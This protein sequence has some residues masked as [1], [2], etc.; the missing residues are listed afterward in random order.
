MNTSK[1]M[2]DVHHWLFQRKVSGMSITDSSRAVMLKDRTLL[3]GAQRFTLDDDSVKLIC[4]LSHEFD[5]LEGWSFLARLPY[6]VTW[7][8]LSL[9]TKVRE[10][11]QM[12]K[13]RYKFNPEEVSPQI[14]YLMYRDA[15]DTS[16]PRWVCQAFLR[17]DNGEIMPSIVAY[18]FDPEGDPK[19]PIR[20]SSFWHAS[21]LSLRPNF[22]RMPVIAALKDGEVTTACDPE[23][24]ISG[25]V[26]WEKHGISGPSWMTPKVAVIIDPWWEAHLE[27]RLKSNFVRT[28]RLILND[29]KENSGHLRWLVTML[30]AING[31][32]KEVKQRTA[33]KGARSVGMYKVPY[34]HSSDISLTIPREDRIIYAHKMLN[35]A[36]SSVHRP[37]HL[38]KGHWRVVEPGKRKYMCRHVPVMVE[39]GLGMCERCE[40]LVRWI[41]DHS[42]GD[43]TLGVVD[44]GY[45]VHT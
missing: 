5:R 38:V 20:G 25:M 18:V 33:S 7:I 6:D 28:C 4:H 3:R 21:T 19:F 43:A 11:E 29:V 15:P 34:F 8:E 2:D 42:R 23:I 22:P 32:P 36:A 26:H 37:W 24:L 41:K 16:S 35:H 30:A 31:L 40:L 12:G 45:N 17:Q 14:G 1:M 27:E 13:L 9:H 10:F 39:Q 44:H